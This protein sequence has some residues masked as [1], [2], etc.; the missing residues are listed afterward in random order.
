MFSLRR[1]ER[2]EPSAG[3]EQLLF[4]MQMGYVGD[5]T[6]FKTTHGKN[7]MGNNIDVGIIM[8]RLARSL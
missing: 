1:C 7:K 4:S 2:A 8:L 5:K 6:R 3:F